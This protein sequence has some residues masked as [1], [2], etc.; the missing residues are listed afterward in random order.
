MSPLDQIA[1]AI[2]AE[3][4]DLDALLPTPEAE[5]VPHKLGTVGSSEAAAVLGLSDW[6]SP[7]QVWARL[8]GLTGSTPD[9]PTLRTG[10]IVEPMMIEWYAKEAGRIIHR[11]PAYEEEP[12]IDLENPWRHARPDGYTPEG[13][14]VEVKKVRNWDD[15]GPDGTDQVP[16]NYLIQCLWQASVAGD[17]YQTIVL[18]A[19]NVMNDEIRI[20]HIPRAPDVEAALLQRIGDWYKAYVLTGTPPPPDGSDG[21]ATI[22][23]VRFPRADKVWLEPTEDD[24]ILHKQ[25]KLVRQTRKQA[26]EAELSLTNTFKERI[27]SASGIRGLVRWTGDKQRRFTVIGEKENE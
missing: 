3:P 6:M 25:L 1:E 26:E 10:R 4:I 20:Y 23:N 7:H 19:F 12:W 5:Y 2:G 16:M 15:W 17:L 13:L 8:V 27:G 22:L 18:I 24:I 14:L 21:C 9:N 11:G